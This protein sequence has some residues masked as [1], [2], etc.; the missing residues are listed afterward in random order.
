MKGIE[1]HSGAPVMTPEELIRSYLE[2]DLS[3]DFDACD[4]SGQG[5]CSRHGHA[6]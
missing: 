4:H 1:V 3:S 2:G 6:D 5:G